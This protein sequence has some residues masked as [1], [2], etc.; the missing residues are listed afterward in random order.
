MI[1]TTILLFLMIDVFKN[2]NKSLFEIYAFSHGPN[3]NKNPWRDK[4]KS[5]FKN[6]FDVANKSDEEIVKLSK[7]VGIDVAV[8][9]TGLTYN[10]RTNIYKMRVAPIQINY[11][12]LLG[13]WV[14]NLLII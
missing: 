1:I 12:G 6:F 14:L 2:H 8:N 9:L 11:L 3:K 7:K 13:P 4:V 10:N 5:Y